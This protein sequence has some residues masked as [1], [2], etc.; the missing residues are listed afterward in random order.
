MKNS[1]IKFV[2]LLFSAFI[3][4]QQ[5]HIIYKVN[6][7]P[8]INNAHMKT[9]HMALDISFDKSI[10]Y[11]VNYKKSDSI[12]TGVK[13]KRDIHYLKFTIKQDEKSYSYYGDF[14]N[15]F[16]TYTEKIPSNWKIRDAQYLYKNYKVQEAEI[17]FEGRKWIAVFCSEIPISKGPYKFS[18]LPGL[19]LKVYSVDGDYN[20]EMVEI[21]KQGENLLYQKS[22]NYSA[23]K[24]SKIDGMIANF[25][26]NPAS[27]NITIVNESE[28]SYDY[29]F[30]GKKDQSYYDMKTYIEEVISKF[31]NPIDK[32]TYILIF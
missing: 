8:Q 7:R 19:I 15:F 23:V 6:F 13:Q 12:V 11:N 21:S 27:G 5:L 10:F 26:K 25:I 31:N 2:F 3:F 14:N 22:G 1:V 16:F 30:S 20:F 18:N 32:K 29:R 4:G 28:D 17:D 9:E 24:K